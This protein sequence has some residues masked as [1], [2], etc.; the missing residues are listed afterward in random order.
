[1]KKNK[2]APITLISLVLM[3]AVI[4][5][6]LIL[7]LVPGAGSNSKNPVLAIYGDTGN[8]PTLSLRNT[9]RAAGFE[10]EILNYGQALP[11]GSSIVVVAMGSDALSVIND[12]R[13]DT[14]VKGFVLICPELNEAYMDNIRS[15]EP[16]CDIAIFAGRDNATTVT[17]MGD[18]RK[19]YERISGDDT[20]YGTPIR[21][22]GLFASKVYVNNAQNRTLSL[23][24]FTVR[25]PSKLLFSPLFQNELAGYLSVTYIDEA[26]R[27]ASFGRINA[28]FVFSWL[29]M[30][31]AVI[32]ILLYISNMNINLTG[33]DGKKAPVSNWV[34][35]LIGGI[36]IAMAIGI[37]ASTSFDAI[38]SAVIFILPFLPAIFMCCLFIINFQWIY[39][40]EGKFV[41]RKKGLVPVV[42]MAVV[43]GSY[44]MLSL[45]MTTDLKIHAIKD[46]SFSSGLMLLMLIA[47]A[48]FATGLIYAS[49]K[50]S[51]AGQGAKNCFGNKL[52]LA[53]MFIP[54]A[55]ALLYG[56]IPGHSDIFYAGLAGLAATFIPY[57]AV[58]P[59][60][61]HTD[62]SLIPGILHGAVYVLVL[63]AVL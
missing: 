43:T 45:A 7:C 1:M 4:L 36:S 48:V 19:L 9:L 12:Y 24:S 63:A 51:A 59:L 55:V 17:E 6:M 33:S 13:D 49:R 54:C 11:S 16:S 42:F 50:S 56:L 34:F 15:G 8:V 10:Y 53:L 25:D 22:G 35:G 39:A 38:R 60:I 46:A 31:M 23:S 5:T 58:V 32:S 40:K 41:P 27:E 2:S 26:T 57:I 61:R 14:H 18:A 47:D 3:A 44:V 37:V 21:R 52:I 30:L 29:A 28:W 20:V 62:R